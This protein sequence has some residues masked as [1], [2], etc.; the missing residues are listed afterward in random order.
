MSTT[1]PTIKFK[2]LHLTAQLFYEA[3]AKCG[4]AYTQ[5]FFNDFLHQFNDCSE[6]KN[7]TKIANAMRQLTLHTEQLST[8]FDSFGIFYFWS[9][10][11]T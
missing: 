4:D 11:Y 8:E 9:C 10:T 5:H 6:L 2:D 7:F 3:E 1:T